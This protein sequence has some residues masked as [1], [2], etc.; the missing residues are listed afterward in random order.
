MKYKN[1]TGFTIVELLIVIVVIAIL[2]AIT[3]VAYNGI[4][5][6]ANNSARYSEIKAWA[7]H[8]E[9]YKTQEGAY[10]SMATGGYCLGSNFPVGGGGLARCRDFNGTGVSSY[11]QSNNDP[12]MTELQKVSSSLPSGLR[13]GVNGTIGP[14]ADYSSSQI[15]LTEVINGTPADCPAEAPSTW[16]DNA[17]RTLCA[18]RLTR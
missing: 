14:Y 13:A 16:T 15:S 10:P 6:R 11:L 2:A 1:Q 5:N 12:L 4:Q 3:I 9:L 8:F 7:K 18:L 17:G